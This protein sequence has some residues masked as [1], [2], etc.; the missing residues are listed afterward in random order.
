MLYFNPADSIVAAFG[1]R[2]G[3]LTTI[4]LTQPFIGGKEPDSERNLWGFFIFL[5]SF[6]L[7]NHIY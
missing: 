3:W 4:F 6:L 5:K 7:C 2:A 1:R